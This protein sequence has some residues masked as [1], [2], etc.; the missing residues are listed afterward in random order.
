MEDPKFSFQG[1]LQKIKEYIDNTKELTILRVVGRVSDLVSGIITDGLFIIFCFF[2]LLFLSISLGFYFGDLFDSN[3]L[4]FLTVTGIYILF[5][6]V[7]RIFKERIE[8]NLVNLSIR[9]FFK[10]WNESD[11]SK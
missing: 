3:S 11:D 6:L 10:K 5:I 8:K 1:V 4:G 2:A 9:K 7:L